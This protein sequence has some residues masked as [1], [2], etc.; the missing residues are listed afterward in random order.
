MASA[1][2]LPGRRDDRPETYRKFPPRERR[3]REKA[4]FPW[5]RKD[6]LA[7]SWPCADRVGVGDPKARGAS[8]LCLHSNGLGR[9]GDPERSEGEAIQTWGLRRRPSPDCLAIARHYG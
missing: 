3:R 9:H 2:S 7:K 1:G 6:A 5:A 4:K 8:M